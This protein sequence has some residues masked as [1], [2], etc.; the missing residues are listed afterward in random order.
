[1]QDEYVTTFYNVVS[2][3]KLKVGFALPTHLEVYVVMLLA[4]HVDKSNFLPKKTFAES[5]LSLTNINKSQAKKLGDACLFVTGVFPEY[6]RSKGFSIDY[7]SSI[8]KNSYQVALS[9]SKMKIFQSLTQHF[10]AVRDYISFIMN[11]KKLPSL[12]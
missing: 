2:E 10:D 6:N 11:K 3:V 9:T 1:M 5:Y 8:G 7:Y 4:D 12:F